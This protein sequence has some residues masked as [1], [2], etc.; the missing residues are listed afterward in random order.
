MNSQLTVAAHILGMLAFVERT[1]DR[2]VTSEELAGSIG[3]HAVVVRRVLRQLAARGLVESRRGVNGGSRLARPAATISLRDAYLAVAP[4]D[5][6]LIARHPGQVGATCRV[7]PAIA[8]V[9][10]G[11]YADAER[12]L[13]DRLAAVDIETF[14]HAV[15]RQLQGC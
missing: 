4:E 5:V 9:L 10:E 8:A 6:E 14:S 12:A 13:L 3:T 7:A 2:R 15:V 11:I 1:E